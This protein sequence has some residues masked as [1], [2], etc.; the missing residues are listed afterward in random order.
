MTFVAE[1]AVDETFQ[2]L[3]AR[4]AQAAKIAGPV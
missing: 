3:G 4:L 2:F 1:Q